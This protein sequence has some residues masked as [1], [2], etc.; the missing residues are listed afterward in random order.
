[1]RSTRVA[2]FAPRFQQEIAS[3]LGLDATVLARELHPTTYC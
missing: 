3:V 2:R 1:M